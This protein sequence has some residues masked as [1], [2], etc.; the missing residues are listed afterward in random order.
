MGKRRVKRRDKRQ[1]LFSEKKLDHRADSPGTLVEPEDAPPP[2]MTLV[3]YD[4]QQLVERNLDKPED[5]PPFLDAYQ[6]VWI[7]VDGLGDAD[8][9]ER[10]G[11]VLTLHPLALE[12]VLNTDHRPKVESYHDN[13]FIV[14][15]MARI[16]DD[17]LDIEQV[18]LFLG[19]KFVLSFQER[20]GDCLDPVR[21]RIRKGGTRLRFLG[22][23]YL[24]YALIDAIIDG[25][26]PVLEHYSDRLNEME[27]RVVAQP[28]SHSVAV[29]HELKR[30]LQVLRHGIWPLREALRTLSGDMPFVR[31]DTR[32]FLRD[33][34][35]HVIQ[36]VDILETYRERAAGLTD[37]Y[38][39]S[40]SNKMNEVMKVLTIIATIFIPLSFVA[41]VYG[42]NFNPDASPFNMPELQWYLGYPFAL[43][44]M[45]LVA[46]ALL[47]YFRRKGWIGGKR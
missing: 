8:L 16:R 28:E 9:L 24:A 21:A 19:E 47:Y 18:S 39:S 3:A 43:G 45:I 20:P 4:Q 13:V 31:D 10:L 38:M 14:T 17:G 12:D 23:D 5:I 7:N 37:L 30:E 42:M 27:D 25:Y 15:R 32:L 26:F 6:V 33:C 11:A 1:R 40:L 46:A 2:V 41:G 35:D 36:V 34:Q 29:I 44:I 22:P